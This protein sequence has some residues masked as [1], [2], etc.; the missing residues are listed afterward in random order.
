MLLFNLRS[1]DKSGFTL[2]G[3]N[4]M[5]F[6]EAVFKESNEIQ[7]TERCNIDCGPV[8]VSVE[9][10]VCVLPLHTGSNPWTVQPKEEN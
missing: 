1:Q 5:F 4:S 9:V 6:W 2:L 7:R 10:D 8:A 3:S